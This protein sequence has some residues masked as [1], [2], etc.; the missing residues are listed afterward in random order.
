MNEERQPP[1]RSRRESELLAAARR[2]DEDAFERLLAPYRGELQ[3]HAYRMLGSLHDA[4]DA[5]QK[6]MLRAWRAIGRFEGR[7]SLR[8]WLYTIATNACLRLIERRP[9]RVLPI[10]LGPSA[11]PHGELSKP[12]VESVWIEPFP[13][14]GVLGP[15]YLARGSAVENPTSAGEFRGGGWFNGASRSP[16]Y[17]GDDVEWAAREFNP[18]LCRSERARS[19]SVRVNRR[20]RS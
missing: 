17:D 19:S 16:S 2:G 13:E 18:T 14:G 7:S 9:K 8:S 4:E 10:D 20:K 12:L 3:A 6:T 5:M 15:G 11:D 1:S